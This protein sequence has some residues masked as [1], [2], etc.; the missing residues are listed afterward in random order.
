MSR[1]YLS[2]GHRY[3]PF[4]VPSLKTP[5]QIFKLEVQP[6]VNSVQLKWEEQTPIASAK[7]HEPLMDIKPLQHKALRYSL[8]RPARVF[9][10]F[11]AKLSGYYVRRGTVDSSEICFHMKTNI[12]SYKGRT[13]LNIFQ[14]DL[15]NQGVKS[16]DYL[17]IR[18]RTPACLCAHE[19]PL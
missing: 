18:R 5:E 13:D 10:G 9:T 3:N 16:D 14:A 19:S 4:E 6:P 12:Y 2:S 15:S 7:P 1:R 8:Y 17:S 11:E